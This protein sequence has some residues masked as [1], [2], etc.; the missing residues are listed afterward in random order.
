MKRTTLLISLVLFI[1]V[2]IVA[3]EFFPFSAQPY[4]GALGAQ[5]QPA[6][7]ADSE[8]RLDMTFLG[9]SLDLSNNLYSIKHKMLLYPFKEE[10]S[11]VMPVEVVANTRSG[12]KKGFLGAKVDLF[13]FMIKLDEKSAIAFTPS[14][15]TKLSITHV[16][17]DLARLIVSDFNDVTLHNIELKNANLNLSTHA[18]AEYGLTYARTVYNDGNHFI[19]AGATVKLLQGLGAGY[20]NIKD[21]S[22]KFTNKDTLSIFKTSVS[23]GTSYDFDI[24]EKL[25]PRF[26]GKP[27]LGFDIG[28]VYE[29]RTSDIDYN[30]PTTGYTKLKLQDAAHYKYKV[31]IAITDI[32]SVNYRRNP[33]SADFVANIENMYIRDIRIDNIEDF[34]RY[35]DSLFHVTPC[36][37][38]FNMA[39]PTSISLQLD[40]RVSKGI[41]LNFIPYIALNKGT[42]LVAKSSNFVSLN[43]I[44][45]IELGNVTVSVPIQYNE[46]N[47]FKTGLA[48]RALFLW[49]GSN[50]LLSNIVKGDI[51]NTNLYFALKF[52]ILFSK[53]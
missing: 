42:S 32:G 39:L 20:L 14:F 12:T 5:F 46:L 23:Y 26:A 2:S 8:Y 51:Y 4:S 30:P 11:E 6:S 31:G 1:N 45:R 22:Y 44:P 48:V 35:T 13:S 41:Y 3:Q 40:A 10:K 34:N 36:T 15:R 47:Q 7:I 52:P 18:W 33:E 24:D 16:S 37:D 29:Y 53:N 49:I 38:D 17:E 27:S 9:V 19:K 43:L 50:D 28:A 21:L 25:K